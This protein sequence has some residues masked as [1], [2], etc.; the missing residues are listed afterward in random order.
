VFSLDILSHRTSVMAIFQQFGVRPS[1]GIFSRSHSGVDFSTYD[2]ISGNP[3]LP[4]I[5]RPAMIACALRARNWP[6]L[7]NQIGTAAAGRAFRS[8]YLCSYGALTGR[9]ENSWNFAPCSTKAP[10]E[11]CWPYGELCGA[12]R[13]CRWRC[14][15][16]LF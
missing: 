14:L 15:L 16:H 8:Q 1:V 2:V 4:I 13:M 10:E 7:T 6:P 5:R 12:A 11:R 9:A 3:A